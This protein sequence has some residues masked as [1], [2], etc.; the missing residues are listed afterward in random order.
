ME[1]AV[2]EYLVPLYSPF[3]TA[4]ISRQGSKLLFVCGPSL[5]PIQKTNA[6][7]VLS[8]YENNHCDKEDKRKCLI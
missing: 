5:C 3:L 7:L 4:K 8:E 2:P 6:E 1:G